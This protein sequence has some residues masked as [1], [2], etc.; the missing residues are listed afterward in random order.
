LNIRNDTKPTKKAFRIANDLFTAW[1]MPL[2]ETSIALWSKLI[3]KLGISYDNYHEMWIRS[4]SKEQTPDT[5][6]KPISKDRQRILI[7]IAFSASAML[8]AL[9]EAKDIHPDFIRDH[10]HFQDGDADG[11]LLRDL[12]TE[13]NIETTP[14]IQTNLLLMTKAWTQFIV[15]MEAGSSPNILSFKYGHPSLRLLVECLVTLEI[16]KVN[17]PLKKLK[18]F[19]RAVYET[20]QSGP[21]FDLFQLI[22][23]WEDCGP[24]V[25]L[26]WTVEGREYFLNP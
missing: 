24:Q 4:N 3:Y 1:E 10:L 11:G 20:N 14:F 2:D 17:D 19:S 25:S 8:D 12:E 13:K 15:E 26:W 6:I 9:H 21:D 7:N 18:E 16:M 23:N 22:P 5:K